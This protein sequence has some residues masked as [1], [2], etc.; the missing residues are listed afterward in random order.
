MSV[1]FVPAAAVIAI[2]V[3]TVIAIIITTRFEDVN[4]IEVVQE[5]RIL[6][7]VRFQC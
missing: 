3:L 7:S 5:F 6:F 4:R 1:K 2:I